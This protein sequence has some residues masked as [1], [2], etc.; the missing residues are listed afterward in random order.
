DDAVGADEVIEAEVIDFRG[1]EAVEVDVIERRGS[2]AVLLHDRKRRARYVVW[3]RA[4]PARHS[5][6]E[7]R[8]A[9]AEIAEEE[10]DVAGHE[11]AAERF[12]GVFGFGFGARFDDPRPRPDGR[13]SISARLI[14]HDHSIDHP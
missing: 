4:D 11:R 5:A 6:H 9:G 13:G 8:L 14:I 10:D 2:S 12:T 7:G 3:I 1:L